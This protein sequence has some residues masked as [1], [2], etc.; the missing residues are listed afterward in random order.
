MDFFG[1]GSPTASPSGLP[2]APPL[3]RQRSKFKT[4][5]LVA[6]KAADITWR[7]SGPYWRSPLAAP[8]LLG[9]EIASWAAF[10]PSML[11]RPWT[12]TAMGT[13]FA[14][15]SG[16]VMGV[17][18]GY[19]MRHTDRWLRRSPLG[20]A[21]APSM[22]T[23]R[24]TSAVVHTAMTA[25][26]V[27]LWIRSVYQQK[28]I[29]QLVGYDELA[30]AR[31]QFGGTALATVGYLTTRGL[32]ATAEL[33]YDQLNGLFSRYLPNL[34]RGIAPAAA[35]AIVGGV[36]AL[37]TNKLL[38][39]RV[40]ERVVRNAEQVNMRV[41]PG[42][43]QPWE[44]QRSGSPWSMEPWIALGAQGRNFVADGPRARDIAAVTGCE[45]HEAFEPIRLYAGKVQGRSLKNQVELVIR[46][47][48][49]TGAF[50]RSHIILHTTTGTGW[51]A[52]WGAT[53]A[54]FLTRGDCAQ[55]GIQYS[56]LPSPIALIAD[57]ETAPTAGREMF[58]R[59]ERELALLP[60]GE[61][62]KLI[63]AGES[64]GAFGGQGAFKNPR[65]MLEKVDGAVWSGTP[66]IT[67]TWKQVVNRRK[68]GSPEIAPVID[69]G[70]NIRF[71]TQPSELW[72]S[73]T[74][75]P[76]GEWEQPRV[77]YLQHASDPIV[78]FDTPLFFRRPD[79]LREKLGRD[80]IRS[81]RWWPV[82]TAWQVLVDCLVSVH[83]A[84]GH[85][86]RY[87]EEAFPAW[88]AVLG[89]EFSE[90]NKSAAGVK[91]SRIARWMRRNH[92]TLK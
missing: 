22:T 28:N 72:S 61:R 21:L 80:V 2:L 70:K 41:M 8:G 91:F 17:A 65:E 13:F 79:W 53:A 51:I 1:T 89:F 30:S 78:W 68:P 77:A 52:P 88:A 25:T 6:L 11:P 36:I 34:P 85:G 84:D 60:E 62:P 90:D 64:L 29:A 86:H 10:A 5:S 14:Q 50:R 76:F 7:V 15:V 75:E 69:D 27:G 4:S 47:M 19:G 67:L 74:G 3:K 43:T 87:E 26:T 82:V 45:P 58:N 73:L 49:R 20:R 54:E 83:V 9:A 31:A 55:I 81:M 37:S 44:P 48:H 35:G 66:R 18:A 39:R 71:A 42:R 16:H 32:T 56:H 57:Q 38:I 23:R 59:L 33:A 46:E 12:S 24:V 63:V 40:V 92:P